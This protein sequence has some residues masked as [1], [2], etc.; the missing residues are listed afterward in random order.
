MDDPGAVNPAVA[1]LKALLDKQTALREVAEERARSS[2]EAL[3]RVAESLCSQALDQVRKNE[4]DSLSGWSADRIADLIIEEIQVQLDQL[5]LANAF[6]QDVI[7]LYQ[8]ATADSNLLNNR[9]DP[10]QRQIESA[11]E[12]QRQAEARAEAAEKQIEVLERTVVDLQKRL[13]AVTHSPA[14]AAERPHP[15]IEASNVDLGIDHPIAPVRLPPG[16][17]PEWMGKWRQTR[18]FEQDVALILLMGETG[19]AR[20][21]RLSQ[22]L[23]ERLGMGAKGGEIKHMFPRL[24]DLGLLEIVDEKAATR[25]GAPHLV[26]LTPKG[27]K[28]YVFLTRTEP[29]P[30]ILDEMLKRHKSAERAYLNLEAADLLEVEGYSVDRYPPAI[31]LSRGRKFLPDLKAISPEGK[32]LWIE[33]EPGTQ[34]SPRDRQEKWTNYYKATGGHFVI[35]TPDRTAMDNVSSEIT[36]WAHTRPLQLWITNLLDVRAGERG[37][38]GS[39]WL[40]QRGGRG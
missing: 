33:V 31:S 10:Y 14:E 35:I 37:R 5:D 30:S 38:D 23:G 2:R 15:Q 9:L 34:T 32:L 1:S 8:Q 17:E 18:S 26:R 29:T 21:N 28:A 22:T 25:G 13:S 27:K 3:Y 7:S 36:Y 12:L 4:P 24:V 40:H 11:E 39:I 16:L 20:R 19:E 6:G